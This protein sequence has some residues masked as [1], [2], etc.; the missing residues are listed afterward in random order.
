MA[1]YLQS[2][3]VVVEM[4][5]RLDSE[6]QAYLKTILT[7]V[8]RF[9][10]DEVKKAAAS[11]K[12]AQEGSNQPSN[13]TSSTP[14]T[15]SPS[16]SSGEGNG[17]SPL[18]GSPLNAAPNFHFSPTPGGFTASLFPNLVPQ[19]TATTPPAGATETQDIPQE[20]V[21][22]IMNSPLGALFASL[23]NAMN[24]A[25]FGGDAQEQ[26]NAAEEE[27]QPWDSVD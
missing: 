21:D 14:P 19:T 13:E 15:G 8:N 11:R 27:V 2:K 16:T 18:G 24:V 6:R 26:V 1:P 3:L 9:M 4:K 25:G 23:G 20:Y 10:V 22:M 12:A 5:S 17:T 7:L